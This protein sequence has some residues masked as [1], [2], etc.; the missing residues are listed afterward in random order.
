V[1]DHL[2]V[3]G[4]FLVAVLEA[5]GVGAGISLSATGLADGSGLVVGLVC[6]DW[7]HYNCRRV[8]EQWIGSK[9]MKFG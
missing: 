3:A 2:G 4:E 7:L 9:V 5:P 8:A 1:L 6:H